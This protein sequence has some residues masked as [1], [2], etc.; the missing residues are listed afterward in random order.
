MLASLA[1]LLGCSHRGGSIT[2]SPLDGHAASS[3]RFGQAFVT[4]QGPGEYDVVLV[5]SAAAWETH[6]QKSSK[7]LQQAPIVP[8]QQMMR[9]HL[10]WRPMIG[11]TKNPAA[12]NAS[13]DWYVL[14]SGTGDLIVYEGAGYVVVEG[15]ELIRKVQIRDGTISAKLARGQMKATTGASRITGSVR[16]V[17]NDGRVKDTIAQMQQ[18]LEGGQ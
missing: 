9:I 4:Q 14:G 3:T 16:A 12:I 5:D 6:G 18:Q 15:D 7:P 10:Y 2:V 17:Y 13:I 11:T 8:V 1:A